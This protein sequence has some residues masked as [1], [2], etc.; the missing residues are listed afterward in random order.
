MSPGLD[1]DWHS[2]FANPKPNVGERTKT[3]LLIVLCALWL[4]FGLTGHAPWRPD[5]LQSISIIKHL[6]NGGD[7]LIPVMAGEATL[8]NPPLYY[9]S[10]ALFAK[11]FS[12]IL[13]LHDA[14]RL[15]T[16]LW[17]TLTLLF[18]GMT[19]RELW[20]T[21]T[22][23]QAA[24]IFI[25]SVGLVFS[26][27]M[28]S[29]E[30]AG[31]CA[32]AAAFYAL[33]LAPRKPLRAGV[34]LGMAA[35]IGFL[36]KGLVNLEIILTTALLLPLLFNH[37]RRSAYLQTLALMLV[38]ATPWVGPWLILLQQKAPDLFN[39]WLTD[40]RAI[41][42][43]TL[44][45]TK[46][47]TW[48]SWPALPLAVWTLWRMRPSHTSIQL[49]LLFF[50]VQFVLLGTSISNNHIYLLPFLLPLTLLA[51]PAVDKLQRS[52][53]S[54]LN[55]FGVM[56]FGV[57]AAFVWTGWV[58]MMTDMPARLAVRVH[59]L[60]SGYVPH[61][62]RVSVALAAAL[63]V[64]WLAVVFKSHRSNRAAITDWAVGMTMVWGLVMTLWLPWLDAAKTYQPVFTAMHK[65][66]PNRFACITSRDVG[67]SQLAAL[68]YYANLHVQR[69]ELVQNLL[70]CDLYLIADDRDRAR[71]EPG[72]DWKLLW[73][74]KRPSDRHESFRLFQRTN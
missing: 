4:V 8:K 40:S 31:L 46:A 69:F 42:N 54:A 3:R 7:W 17:T 18:V 39:T 11:L 62:N 34:I 30:V 5:E 63:T 50:L 71:I 73:E 20:G 61:F 43:R 74:G 28:L 68:D 59:V 64:L 55:W 56:V 58:A 48:Y 1:H 21:G 13:P 19:G 22:G 60:S 65:A 24:L 29:P 32:Y 70:S 26:A 10:A 37:W 14:A 27:H 47:L 6:V 52:F 23:R 57:L 38:V 51:T 35:G 41:T 72:Q 33:S 44:F 9:L 15:V 45:V 53:A 2:V 16:S 36:S 49:A 12:S 67:P 25:S 66:M